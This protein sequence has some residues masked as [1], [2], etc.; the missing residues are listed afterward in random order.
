MLSFTLMRVRP[1]QFQFRRIY[2]LSW[3]NS[4]RF[5]SLDFYLSTPGHSV[6]LGVTSSGVLSCQLHDRS[7][8]SL[9]GPPGASNLLASILT[10]ETIE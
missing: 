6:I 8:E 5:V 9:Q 7:P 10:V 2:V 1:V 4:G 3:E